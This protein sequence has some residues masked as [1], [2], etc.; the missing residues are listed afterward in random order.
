MDKGAEIHKV[1]GRCQDAEI[2]DSSLSFNT[3]GS[4]S[5]PIIYDSLVNLSRLLPA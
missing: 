2:S 3:L 4:G 1:R 5:I